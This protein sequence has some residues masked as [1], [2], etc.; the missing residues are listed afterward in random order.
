MRTIDWDK[1]PII[2]NEELDAYRHS[3]AEARKKGN[4]MKYTYRSPNLTDFEIA[5]KQLEAIL[6]LLK[7]KGLTEDDKSV[8]GL[9]YDARM[10][11]LDALFATQCI[12]GFLENQ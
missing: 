3:I 5:Q 10:S 6:L 11:T 12:I 1:I 7:S 8:R 2:T 4:K 9:I